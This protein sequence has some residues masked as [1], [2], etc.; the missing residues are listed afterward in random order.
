MNRAVFLG[1]IALLSGGAPCLAQTEIEESL[2]GVIVA[3]EV[4]QTQQERPRIKRRRHAGSK[5]SETPIEEQNGPPI[6]RH[7]IDGY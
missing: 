4:A 5:A 7:G 2:A 3:G 1:F 6:D